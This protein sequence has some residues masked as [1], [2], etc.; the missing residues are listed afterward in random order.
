MFSI[1]PSTC[2]L[3]TN[4]DMFPV[5]KTKVGTSLIIVSA[6]VRPQNQPLHVSRVS[7]WWFALLLLHLFLLLRVSWTL[8]GVFRRQPLQRCPV[9]SHLQQPLFLLLSC[10]LRR[11]RAAA[12][13]AFTYSCSDLSRRSNTFASF[14]A[15]FFGFS[16]PL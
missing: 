1:F 15:N 16:W 10:C 11:Q 5:F 8:R 3:S 2:R 7:K 6:D 9:L 4:A 12:L 13:I 14:D